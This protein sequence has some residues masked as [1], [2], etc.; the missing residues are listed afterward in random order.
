MTATGRV[1]THHQLL[2]CFLA[3]F[4][5]RAVFAAALIP[6]W[7]GPDEPVHFVTAYVLTQPYTVTEVDIQAQV[8]ESMARHQWWKAYDD[9]T[10]DPLPKNFAEE[11]GHRFGFGHFSQ[12][13]YYGL[14]AL[15][16]RVTQPASLE[17]AYYHLRGLSV[18]FSLAAL[19]MGW[20]G[21]RILLGTAVANGALA[22]AVLLPQFLFVAVAVNPDALVNFWGGFIWWQTA[23]VAT[24]YRAAM[25]RLLLL[26]GAG[27]GVLAQRLAVPLAGLA[28]LVAVTSLLMGRA[29]F[30]VSARD[31]FRFAGVVAMG[32][33]VL[34]LAIVSFPEAF[35]LLVEE[36]WQGALSVR[37]SLDTDRLFHA[38]RFLPTSVDRSWLVAGW[39]RFPA[40][41]VWLWA[42]RVLTLAAVVGAGVVTIESRALR[43]RLSLAWLFVVGQY[44]SV[45]FVVVLVYG[46]SPQGRYFFPVLAPLTTLLYVGLTR[47]VPAPWQRYSPV[48]ITATLALMDMT[49]LAIVPLRVYLD[50]GVG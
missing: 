24:G 19:V 28:S 29:R 9:P 38:L 35:R 2:A 27:A 40:P 16:L 11:P 43:P 21:T 17:A 41:D 37:Q 1:A 45:M 3:L 26:V 7:Q 47:W 6:P 18:A 15:T 36:R 33:T 23:Y 48:A 22:I 42:A 44:L 32:V 39:V 4:L 46:T 31:V 30:R 50:W 14:S 25:G 34:A 5:C 8:L 13:L 49:G 10:P 20:L 12:P